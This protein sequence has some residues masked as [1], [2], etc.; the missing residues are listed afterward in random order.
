MSV[1]EQFMMPIK[2][3]S[4]RIVS[5]AGQSVFTLI[6]VS[7]PNG[8]SEQAI[9]IINGNRQPQDAYTVDSSSQITMSESL[10]LNDLVEIVVIGR[11]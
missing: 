5:S 1:I 9:V 2:F 3:K 6:T 4:E 7:I 10:E 11:K 8:D